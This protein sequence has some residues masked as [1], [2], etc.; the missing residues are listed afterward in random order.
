MKIGQE[1]GEN[2]QV[3][4]KAL[5]NR[6]YTL[7]FI[8]KRIKEDWK[9]PFVAIYNKIFDKKNIYHKNYFQ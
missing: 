9:S 8:I 7:K 2:F 6:K 5:S 3:E 4:Q 1:L